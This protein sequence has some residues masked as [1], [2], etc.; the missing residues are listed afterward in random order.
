MSTRMQD[1]LAR[2]RAE[3]RYEPIERQLRA[4]LGA[5][6]VVD[7]RRAVLLWEPRRVVPSYA[8]PADDIRAPL[9]IAEA[10]PP[11]GDQPRVL[12][13]G[14]P[15]AVHTA[16]GEPVSVAGR[17]GA[18]FR[19][20]D[21]ALAGYV[22]LDFGAFDAWY[23]EADRVVGHP[24]DPFHR[25]D[26]RRSARPVHVELGGEVL[27]ETTDARLLYETSLPVRF[28]LPR[29]DLRV[30]LHPGDRRTYCPYKGQASYWSAEAGGARREDIAWSYEEP[31]GDAAGVAGLVAFW[32]EQVDVFLDGRRRER[33]GGA[34]AD[35]LRDEF[36]V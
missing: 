10:V 9:G 6:T 12:H 5:E 15:F 17:D 7:S 23:E 22:V 2:A 4:T 1:L 19:L 25:I 24:R 8:V 21:A 36:G 28:Y 13:P 16:D 33:P 31:L 29:E 3:L 34:V 35:S 18:G 20:A 32:D 26:V 27:A 30:A 14:V 11:A